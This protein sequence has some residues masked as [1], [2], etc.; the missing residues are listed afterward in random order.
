MLS[1][2][3]TTSAARVSG[4]AVAPAT[5]PEDPELL[6]I[7]AY[8]L[9]HI[10]RTGDRIALR[11]DGLWLVGLVA[12]TLMALAERSEQQSLGKFGV[13]PAVGLRID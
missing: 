9:R 11:S 12:L 7:P 4:I 2:S 5:T 1:R 3:G 13:V 10:T 8:F 6:R